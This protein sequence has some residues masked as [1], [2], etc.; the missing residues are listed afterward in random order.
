VD[1]TVSSS[2]HSRRAPF[3]ILQIR[4]KE[5][6][7]EQLDAKPTAITDRFSSTADVPVSA[8]MSSGT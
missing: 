6:I 2:A 7:A 4:A 3:T 1:R 5:I 8:A